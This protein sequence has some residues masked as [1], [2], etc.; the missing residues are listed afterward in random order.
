MLKLSS[1]AP[2]LMK[3][4]EMNTN[5]YR[6]NELERVLNA[7]APFYRLRVSTNGGGSCSPNINISAAELQ[8]IIKLLTERQP[9]TGPDQGSG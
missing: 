4:G 2:D 9:E 1:R 3:G 8:A 7:P 5:T 6:R